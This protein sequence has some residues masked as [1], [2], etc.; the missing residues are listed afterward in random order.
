MY[1]NGT[2]CLITVRFYRTFHI[3]KLLFLEKILYHN[4]KKNGKLNSTKFYNFMFRLSKN[5]IYCLLC[6]SV[7]FLFS[8]HIHISMEIDISFC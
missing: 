5:E 1:K 3:M 7:S 6:R 8:V 4:R 2:D